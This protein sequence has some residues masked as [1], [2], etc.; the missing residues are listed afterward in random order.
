MGDR[1]L[2]Q[3]VL[4]LFVAAGADRARPDRLMPTSTNGCI[5]PMR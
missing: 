4:G 5:L 2:E 1:E 3:E